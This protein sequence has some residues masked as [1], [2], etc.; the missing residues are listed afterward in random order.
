[1][2]WRF[3]LFNLFILKM[4]V[5]RRRQ[6]DRNFYVK[7]AQKVAART[8][9]TSNL[10]HNVFCEKNSSNNMAMY[11]PNFPI[12]LVTLVGVSG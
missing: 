5:G 9:N 8:S 1:V 3:H 4:R 2:L 7:I 10:I 11:I 6:G 12:K